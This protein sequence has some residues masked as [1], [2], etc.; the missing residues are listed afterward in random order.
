[1]FIL[2]LELHFGYMLLKEEHT[3]SHKTGIEQKLTF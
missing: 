3:L 2:P 1:M